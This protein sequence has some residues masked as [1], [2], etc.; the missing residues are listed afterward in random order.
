[1]YSQVWLLFTEDKEIVNFVDKCKKKHVKVVLHFLNLSL[2][3]KIVQ[4]LINVGVSLVNVLIIIQFIGIS[5]L[6]VV[7]MI[8]SYLSALGSL[9]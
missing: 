8:I 1:M 9:N 6:R 3:T 7:I 2:L 5:F 4:D